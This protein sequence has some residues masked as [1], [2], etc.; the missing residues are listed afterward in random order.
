[1]IDS[2][3]W[4]VEFYLV[5]DSWT[6]VLVSSFVFLSLSH[7]VM[8]H[9]LRPKVRVDYVALNDGTEAVD[10]ASF[11]NTMDEV[12]DGEDTKQAVADCVEDLRE[13]SELSLDELKTLTAEE[14]E[15]ESVLNDMMLA[16]EKHDLLVKL[17]DLKKSNQAREQKMK[18]PV[19]VKEQAST[20]GKSQPKRNTTSKLSMKDLR[21]SESFSQEVENYLTSLGM[22]DKSTNPVIGDIS[23]SSAAS[24][25]SSEED[26]VDKVVRKMKKGKKM[27]S[28]KTAKVT[29]RVLKPQIWPQSELCLNFVSKDIKYEDLTIEEFVAGYSAIL[30]S[31]S[32]SIKEREDRLE[33]LNSIMHLAIVH[34]WSS[35]KNFH[36]AVLLEIERGKSKWGDSFLHLEHRTLTGH[37]KSKT[38]KSTENKRNMS[39]VLFCRDFQREK[40]T[41]TKDHFSTIKGERKWV[42]HI[43]ATCWI[44]DKV[45]KSHT[46][47]SSD[48]LH[49]KPLAA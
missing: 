11:K 7:F 2:L 1:M 31:K 32:I 30:M 10:T 14:E 37:A 33:H 39:G 13:I 8:A 45:K 28:G 18:K 41:H 40:C 48:C 17:A 4:L 16:R 34:D 46:E 12:G 23:S 5:V 3:A 22:N 47:F 44:K 24:G 15:K 29:S 21:A 26:Q 43:C 6:L 36:A 35:I 25:L 27:K 38:D 9:S 42:S 49:N 20:S 19:M